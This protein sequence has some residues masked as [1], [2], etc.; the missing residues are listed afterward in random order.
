MI[1]FQK[2]K[3]GKV[4]LISDAV[5]WT[6][7]QQEANE[8]YACLS[9]RPSSWSWTALNSVGVIGKDGIEISILLN[10]REK[11]KDQLQNLLR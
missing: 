10:E 6:L 9:G 5:A 1:Y 2:Q 8:L 4:T 11:L 7:S 3:K